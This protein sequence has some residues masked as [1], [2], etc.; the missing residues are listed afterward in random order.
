MPIRGYLEKGS[1]FAGHISS[2]NVNNT[3][4]DYCSLREKFGYLSPLNEDEE[5][6][7]YSSFNEKFGAGS[8]GMLLSLGITAAVA[9]PVISGFSALLCL[10]IVGTTGAAIGGHSIIQGVYNNKNTFFRRNESLP[11]FSQR[12]LTVVISPIVSLFFALEQTVK[13]LGYLA[14]AIACLVQ[15]DLNNCFDNIGRSGDALIK[16]S[17]NLTAMISNPIINLV[18]VAGSLVMPYVCPQ[19]QDE[20]LIETGPTVTFLS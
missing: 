17:S 12:V 20:N 8:I 7:T 6:G 13:Y 18:D 2:I 10:C 9:G 3:Q 11:D 1:G 5:F 19:T 4:Y 14:K 16:I 15:L